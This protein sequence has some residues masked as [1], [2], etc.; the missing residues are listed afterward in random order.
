[1]ASPHLP[2]LLSLFLLFSLY[3]NADDL[4]SDRAALL[5]F[6]SAVA[7]RLTDWNSSNS[8]PCSWKGIRCSSNRVTDIRLPASGLY[9]ELP[10]GVLGN[11]TALRVLSLRH[12]FLTG[13]IPSD[14]ARCTQLTMINL[15]S[16][17]LSGVI[18]SAIFS[19]PLLTSLTLSNNNFSGP[20][21]ADFNNMT[22]LNTLYLQYNQLSGEIPDLNNLTNLNNFNVSYN[23][24]N[25]SV[26]ASLR[27][28]P[29]DSFLGMLQLCG[30]PRPP[31]AGAPSS[32]PAPGIVPSAPTPGNTPSAPV[33]P[34]GGGS[35]SS[36]SK[37]SGGAIAGIAVGSVVG[38]LII[39][40]LLVF[41]CGKRNAWP[42]D[43]ATK[44][45]V[46][47]PAMRPGEMAG[48]PKRSSAYPIGEPVASVPASV[49][50]SSSKK[51]SFVGNASRV[52][53]LEDLLRASAEVLGKGTFGT[54]YKAILETG[55]VVAVKRLKDAN[56]PE[57]EFRD[58]VSEIGAMNNPY[59]VPLQAYY[60]SRDEK[61]L[62]YE[63]V[64]MGSLSSL[65]HGHRGSDHMA[66][67]FEAR[68]GI[69][70]SAARGIEYIHS[71]GP[72]ASHGN[73]KSS[74]VLLS[75]LNEARIADQ[76]LAQLV[77]TPSLNRSARYRAPE[78]TDIRKI[79]QK[80]DVYS[81]GV[82]L[83][84]LLTGRTPSNAVNNEEGVDLPRWVQSVPRDEWKTKVFDLELVKQ[85][86]AEQEMVLLLQL[87]IDCTAQHP[88]SR[89]MMY[90][91]ASRI[92][93]I[94]LSVSGQ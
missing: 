15:D 74:N 89:P 1:M 45:M 69:A 57:K 75:G 60:Y 79:S 34:S 18:P 66:L 17:G 35:G 42:K 77:T 19:L 40:A 9:G 49:S 58:K 52:Y 43:P 16:N 78:V 85:Q 81:F 5:A 82:L 12:N 84:E 24:F 37:L 6:R 70:L 7:P 86:T 32:A 10:S 31:C 63:Y 4:T 3:S 47:A 11:L 36:S 72:R 61:L 65:L 68:A 23:N 25:G 59:L 22:Q 20:F 21:P 39:L 91:V 54:T 38:A 73:I 62:V 44:P 2:L 90:E 26:P 8:S 46:G 88:D 93:E 27:N 53:D 94:F 28:M 30:Q 33:N 92:D 13:T 80:A 76:G 87:A 56:L 41:F 48:L 29:E 83:M 50:T 64:S 51:L 14:L 67:S 71:T 55:P